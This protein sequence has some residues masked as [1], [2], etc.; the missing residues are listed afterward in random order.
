MFR[1]IKNNT[2]RKV[3]LILNS[4]NEKK[5]IKSSLVLG[6]ILGSVLTI[7]FLISE[8]LFDKFVPEEN[9]EIINLFINEYLF[10]IILISSLLLISLIL[11]LVLK[12]KSY[13]VNLSTPF[14]NKK[15]LLP[16]SYFTC[17]FIVVFAH[18]FAFFCFVNFSI[19]SVFIF[20][21]ASV[22]LIID[23][24]YLII[25][26]R[27]VS[28]NEVN[29]KKAYHLSS[30]LDKH[31]HI[32]TN[33]SFDNGV[34]DKDA[35]DRT[36][37]L[38]SI[39]KT[40]GDKES[41]ISKIYVIEGTWGSGKTTLM[42]VALNNLLKEENNNIVF[43][44][45]SLVNYKNDESL[46][47]VIIETISDSIENNIFD[48][49]TRK[50]IKRIIEQVFQ[51][52]TGIYFY[53]NDDNNE[54][55][56]FKN[57]I[58]HYLE[59]NDIYLDIIIDDLDRSEYSLI[60]DTYKILNMFKID[61]VRFY[62]LTNEK[63]IKTAFETKKENYLSIDKLV[64]AKI[65]VPTISS[66]LLNKLLLNF[67]L[68][69]SDKYNR[70]Y[71]CYKGLNDFKTEKSYFLT[72]RNLINYFNMIISELKSPINYIDS[73]HLK[74]ILDCLKITYP[75]VYD[76][77]IDKRDIIIRKA[78]NIDDIQ[79]G[80][81]ME[82]YIFLQTNITN[83]SL[84]EE[85]LRKL[86]PSLK[87]AV[88]NNDNKA[89]P[90][91][92]TSLENENVYNFY[93]GD[94]QYE[95]FLN[96]TNKKI[97]EMFQNSLKSDT[98]QKF[99]YKEISFA[100]FAAHNKNL[101]YVNFSSFFSDFFRIYTS[102]NLNNLFNATNEDLLVG[103][104]FGQIIFY[105]NQ[106]EDKIIDYFHNNKLNLNSFLIINGLLTREYTYDGGIEVNLE[107][108]LQLVKDNYFKY[109]KSVN[110]LS[111]ITSE[112][113]IY[114]Y[115][116]KVFNSFYFDEE[117]ISGTKIT[118]DDDP[119]LLFIF[120]LDFVNKQNISFSNNYFYLNSKVRFILNKLIDESI[121]ELLEKEKDEIVNILGCD[122]Y[123]F[124]FII[125]LIFNEN[126]SIDKKH[127]GIDYL[128][129]N[130]T[131]FIHHISAYSAISYLKNRPYKKEDL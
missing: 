58:N 75:N 10:L 96:L 78:K 2:E 37:T 61:R 21:I 110:L 43:K 82:L 125:A 68:K 13:K 4:I 127:F 42:K 119:V 7:I 39:I 50:Y 109:F 71:L 69:I 121:F 123:F 30:L 130:F 16:L 25:R 95:D 14:I 101:E 122:S 102:T 34:S 70:H 23:F 49:K 72:P 67:R 6:F 84:L 3:F 90:F 120:I 63:I 12:F 62:L 77:I 81:L 108:S 53:F 52:K 44:Y 80:Q 65:Y 74:F 9:K 129:H 89:H 22:L 106:Q 26:L 93:F 27:N 55:S 79:V 28:K 33:V 91:S 73:Y 105:C 107:N 60:V 17:G 5:I 38:N 126:V 18:I 1:K 86:F 46:I 48:F 114:T 29:K 117:L 103:K 11:I 87:D 15:D 104:L 131:T 56:S 19:L 24:I 20:V 94:F 115:F 92:A 64:F 113:Y 116:S 124:D 99:T 35:F 31:F 112:N 88:L 97:N 98:T 40:L 66:I 41:T 54:I 111:L 57:Y 47:S 76:E 32:D 118:K 100:I 36:D 8:H 59:K 128:D 45:I 85:I 51:K 83:T